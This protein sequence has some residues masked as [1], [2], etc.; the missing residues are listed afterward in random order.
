MA[1]EFKKRY[2]A[3][4]MPIGLLMRG[5]PQLDKTE[6]GRDRFGFLNI[7]G[8]EI[9]R[10][11]VIATVVDKYESAEKN[12]ATLTI[13]D[14]TDNI[15]VKA[16]S[17]STPV[18]KDIQL[19]DTIIV[20]GLLRYYN[21]EIYIQPELV[22]HTDPRWLLARKLELERDLK[23]N[24]DE[25][26]A[27]EEPEEAPQQRSQSENVDVTE[28]KL[29]TGSETQPSLREDIITIIKDA[30]PQ[31]GLGIDEIIMKLKHPV[32]EIKDAVTDLLESGEIF[33]PRPG[34]LR[35][36]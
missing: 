20:I 23:I 1:T 10:V 26:T 7:E 6:D 5:I 22:K 3:Y 24:Y 25:I 4:R 35:I 11:N 27:T 31:E 9:N 14:G 28:E 21:D 15:R 18:I 29:E 34:K 36:L 32:E 17:D 8:K 33:E 19:G 13:D 2:T 12:Y 30:E 16:F